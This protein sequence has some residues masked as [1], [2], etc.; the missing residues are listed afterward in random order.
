MRKKRISCI[1][2][3]TV[4][5]KHKAKRIEFKVFAPQAEKIYLCGSFNNWSE[6]SDPMKKDST[7]T[8]KKIKMLLEGTH[9]YKYLMVTEGNRLAGI[10]SLKDMLKFLELKVELEP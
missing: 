4:R 5:V 2:G 10:I 8:S 1:P 6:S 7:G 3:I 9:E